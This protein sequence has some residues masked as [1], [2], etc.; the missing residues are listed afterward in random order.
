[1]RASS[2]RFLWLLL[3]PTLLAVLPNCSSSKS[4]D[5]SL[6]YSINVT[7]RDEATGERICNAS[8]VA[9]DGQ[10]QEALQCSAATDCTC[11]GVGERLGTYEVTVSAPGYQ[12]AKKTVVVD[13]S[14]ECHVTR[15]NVEFKL[16]P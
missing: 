8:V 12:T 6:H 11:F 2:S 16:A 14:D 1:M 5:A 9:Q 4:C 7:V 10:F 15:E 3:G 13:D